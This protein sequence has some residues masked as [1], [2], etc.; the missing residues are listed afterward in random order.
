MA[1]PPKNG[2]AMSAAERS[3][4]YRARRKAGR[5]A[6]QAERDR[7]VDMMRNASPAVRKAACIELGL[8]P[9]PFEADAMRYEWRRLLG[10]IADL[11]LT[12]RDIASD[13]GISERRVA[14]TVSLGEAEVLDT[15]HPRHKDAVRIWR[16]AH[17]QP[18][19]GT[20]YR[21]SVG[22]YPRLEAALG[23]DAPHASQKAAQSASLA[24]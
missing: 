1:R 17:R 22:T 10:E 3:R 11:G 24:K 5:N 7:L 14:G 16:W 21:A 23:L 12:A 8:L 18:Q 9:E 19:K 4:R 6:K 2:S 13:V 15:L 20:Q